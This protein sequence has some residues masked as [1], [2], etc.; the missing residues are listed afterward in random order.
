M[1]GMPLH[2]YPKGAPTGCQISIPY[3][4]LDVDLCEV[5]VFLHWNSA[6]GWANRTFKE[7]PDS[8]CWV[9]FWTS[10]RKKRVSKR[11]RS[12][13]TWNQKVPPWSGPFLTSSLWQIWSLYLKL[14]IWPATAA[15]EILNWEPIFARLLF[16]CWGPKKTSSLSYCFASI[17][18]QG[19][20]NS[21]IQ[22]YQRSTGPQHMRGCYTSHRWRRILAGLYLPV[23]IRQ[24][25]QQP[26]G[27]TRPETWLDQVD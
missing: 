20:L 18:I 22:K 12:G 6:Y 21:I 3:C 26:A 23:R 25:L 19:L 24:E 1:N 15:A 16:L 13:P 2:P 4:Q 8:T 14:M 17:S 5:D 7:A 9:L 27:L 10:V 11:V